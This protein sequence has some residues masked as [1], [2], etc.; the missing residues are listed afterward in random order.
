MK[1]FERAKIRIKR[2]SNDCKIKINVLKYFGIMLS[3]ER[4]NKKNG[5]I[6]WVTEKDSAA[7]SAAGK[8]NS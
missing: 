4:E 7:D 8:C 5:V 6:L 2:L 3:P 1:F